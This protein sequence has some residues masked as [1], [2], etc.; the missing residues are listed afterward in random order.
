[1]TVLWN[2]PEIFKAAFCEKIYNYFRRK[3]Q[4]YMFKVNNKNT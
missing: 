2:L 3:N 4:T 1:M